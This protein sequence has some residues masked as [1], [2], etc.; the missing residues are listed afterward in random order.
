[1]YYKIIGFIL[2]G[3]LC[4]NFSFSRIVTKIK[5]KNDNKKED[6]TQ[7]GS[8]NPGTM[9]MLRTQGAL[10]GMLTLIFDAL[11]SAI[12]SIIAFYVFG[13]LSNMPYSKIAIYITGLSAVVGHIY[14]VFYG[15]KGGKG[16]ASSVGVFFVANP[17]VSLCI[18]A[19]CVIF[20]LFVKI[21]SLTSFL[22]IFS[23]AVFETF[24]EK[25]FLVPEII[26]LLWLIIL[27]DV[28]AHRQ[29][30]KKLFLKSERITSLQEGVKKDVER[31]KA[32]KQNKIENIETKKQEKLIEKY[33]TKKEMMGKKFEKKGRKLDRKFDKREEKLNKKQAKTSNK[34]DK[35]AN[36]LLK[37]TDKKVAKIQKFIE[38][39]KQDDGG[40]NGLL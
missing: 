38:S 23:F 22:F 27:L 15:F 39:S 26:I 13:G 11:K 25:N 2:L 12:P 1:M 35:K 8:G 6:I 30:I 3:Y 36:K 21:G 29:N 5:S 34:Y 40:N 28:F 17:I 9:N 24:W 14:P 7:N 37:K 4:G 32:K 19:C 31:L 10:W 16:I 18:L 20:F 33:N